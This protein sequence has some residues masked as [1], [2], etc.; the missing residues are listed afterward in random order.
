MPQLSESDAIWAADQFIA[1]YSQFQR[2]DEYLRYIK[3][4]RLEN[5]EATLFGPEDDIFSDFSVH[6]NDMQFSIHTADTSPK[7]KSRYCQSLYREVLELTT[8][9]AIEEAIPGRT[10]KWINTEDTTGKIVGTLWVTDDQ[11]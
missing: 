6:P 11:Q 3:Q 5:A 10:I 4:Y 8:S 2:I 7:P 9:A 1:Y